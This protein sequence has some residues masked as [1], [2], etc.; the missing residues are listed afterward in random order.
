MLIKEARNNKNLN[1]HDLNSGVSKK[2]NDINFQAYAFDENEK[3]L[4]ILYLDNSLESIETYLGFFN[5]KHCIALLNK[6]LEV[7]LK[8]DIEKNYL[9]RY[10]YDTAREEIFGYSK[11]ESV[12]N[13]FVKNDK[14]DQKLKFY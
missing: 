3:S 7:S 12:E 13:V 8:I 11:V 14:T 5:S 1:F 9:P 4:V 6:N 2:I 10:I